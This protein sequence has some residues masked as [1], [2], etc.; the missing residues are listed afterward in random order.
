MILWRKVVENNDDLSEGGNII[1]VSMEV[2]N[3]MYIMMQLI[4][5]SEV[6]YF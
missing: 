5:N 6:Y 2:G 4:S 1:Y 3:N